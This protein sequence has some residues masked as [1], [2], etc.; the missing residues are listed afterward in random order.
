MRIS[1]NT[2]SC[3]MATTKTYSDWVLLRRLFLQ[4]RRFWPHLVLLLGLSLLAAPLALLL[5]V[6]LKM[7][8]DN[9]LGSEP[10][11]HLL[12]N[13][14]PDGVADDK[15]ML[16]LVMG[17]LLVV[18]TFLVYFR[19][20]LD[21][22]L[23]TY[24]GEKMLLSFRSHIMN[25]LQKLSFIYHDTKGTA[26]SIYRVQY[27]TYCIQQITMG[28][29][30]PLIT[31]L[32]MI[33]S[34]LFI[35]F[36]LDWQIALVAMGVSPILFFLTW[37][38]QDRM[39]DSWTTLKQQESKALSIVQELLTS[40][41]T[42]KAFGQENR[43]QNR[44]VTQSMRSLKQ[45]MHVS[46]LGAGF[47]LIIGSV[48]AIGSATILVL[49]VHHVIHQTLSIGQLLLIMAYLTEL[50]TPL[51]EIS[52]TIA[53]LQSSF[54]SAQ[55]VFSLLDEAPSVVEKAHAEA[56]AVAEGHIEFKNVSFSYEGDKRA[57]QQ[58]SFRI[59]SGQ[60]V[61]I[62]G[63]TGAGK[64]TLIS[65][66]MRF[67]DPTEGAIFLDGTNM[68]DYRLKDLRNQ[69]AIVLQEPVL[70]ATSIAANIAYADPSASEEQ[71]IAAAK[72]AHAHEFIS[73]LPQ[74]YETN[75][76]ERGMKLSGGERQRL[77][78]ARAFLKN[79]PIMIFDEPTS[80]VDSQTEALIMDA[81]E[82]L[83]KDRTTIMIAH[84]MSTLASCDVQ[85]R[86]ENGQLRTVDP[87]G[88]MSAAEGGV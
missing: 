1:L 60:K 80:S 36:R 67:Y 54:S 14:L 21:W 72:A 66:L 59:H 4:A 69:F 20:M 40:I 32:F 85:L 23:M 81:M 13:L 6:P 10:L 3:R 56:L 79:A 48:I 34:I 22:L 41:R 24:T 19:S 39:R 38:Y 82:R 37:Y 5:P 47:N 28:S 61:G 77:T 2:V 87:A 55:R 73:R 58:V 84:R 64:S 50:F 62:S 7:A 16:T 31:S 45:H 9:V 33:I 78:L 83:M 8:V 26:D 53:D 76:G 49:G 12:A 43:E 51:Q 71:I 70:F 44:F 17:A 27:D 46:W 74:G 86:I 15:I 63:P 30:K 18:F 11:P 29:L 25:H 42:I 65:L 75:V 68:R 35:L 88:F 57:L 52:K